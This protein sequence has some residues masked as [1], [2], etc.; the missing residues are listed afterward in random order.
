MEYSLYFP[1]P[2]SSACRVVLFT[3]T[4]VM[5][6]FA[7]SCLKYFTWYPRRIPFTWSGGIG[8]HVTLILV[9]LVLNAVT[10]GGEWSGTREEKGSTSQNSTFSMTLS[11]RN[12][13]HNRYGKKSE[14]LGDSMTKKSWWKHPHVPIFF[15]S[16]F[17]RHTLNFWVYIF[18][19]ITTLDAF[20]ITDPER[21]SH[22]NLV[23][24]LAHHESP[25]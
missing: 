18:V 15:Y 7:L 24:D 12:C 19:F 8:S 16:C 9:E 11:S 4:M 20:D 21:M 14:C 17:S 3:V 1:N 25:V 10:F 6:S 23:N 5:L 13:S 2:F 22:M